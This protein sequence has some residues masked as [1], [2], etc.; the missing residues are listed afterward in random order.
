MYLDPDL[1]SNTDSGQP[2]RSG[3]GLINTSKSRRA[4]TYYFEYSLARKF[5]E[6]RFGSYGIGHLL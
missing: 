4:I 5:V 1:H 6:L 3:F 2:N